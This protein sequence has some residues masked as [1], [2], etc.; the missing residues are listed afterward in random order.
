MSVCVGYGWVPFSGH[1]PRTWAG[2]HSTPWFFQQVL[3]G[4][5]MIPMDGLSLGRSFGVKAVGEHAPPLTTPHST[6]IDAKMM[7][8]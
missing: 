2:G 7:Q 1:T 8:A 6:F 5:T 3:L 4:Y